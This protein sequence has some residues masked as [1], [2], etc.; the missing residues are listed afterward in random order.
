MARKQ[1]NYN[2]LVGRIG[3]NYYVCDYIFEETADWKGA[4]A[5]VVTPVSKAEY[6]R[7]MDSDDSDTQEWLKEQWQYAVEHNLTEG[8]LQEFTRISLL[9]RG[10]D[11]VFDCGYYNLWD[12]IRKAVPELTED[13][14]PV[15]NA[16]GGGRSFSPDMEWDEIYNQELWDKIKVIETK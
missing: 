4:T 10:D 3:D 2:L 9:N 14:Y 11:A 8:S 13:D 12:M 1:T 7:K 6:D 15:L 5:S 16:C